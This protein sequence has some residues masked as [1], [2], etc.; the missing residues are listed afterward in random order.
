M[1]KATL[2]AATAAAATS[3]SSLGVS[4]TN[5]SPT[6]A[7]LVAL[8]RAEAFGQ[9]AGADVSFSMRTRNTELPVSKHRV[10]PLCLLGMDDCLAFCEVYLNALG[11]IST[12]QPS[13]WRASK[14]SIDG[15]PLLL[16][17]KLGPFLHS[18]LCQA[19]VRRSAQPAG[20][21]VNVSGVLLPCAIRTLVGA[22]IRSLTDNVSLK[23]DRIGDAPTHAVFSTTLQNSS[24]AVVLGAGAIGG[25]SS[26]LL[27]SATRL[28]NHL[29][30][31]DDDEL[32]HHCL[33]GERVQ[34]IVCTLSPCKQW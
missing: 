7:D 25:A 1:P 18:T 11:Q 26:K 28:W 29:V 27:N 17:R 21:I 3:S 32:Y 4:N 2:A 6:K 15:L 14:L 33:H 20:D 9:T 5:C 22:V 10:P 31:E 12:G 30:Q 34:T 16:C 13:S 8:R 24:N 23:E 19:T